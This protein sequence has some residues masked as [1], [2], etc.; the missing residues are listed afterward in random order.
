MTII[1]RYGIFILLVGLALILLLNKVFLWGFAAMGVGLIIFG[2]QQLINLNVRVSQFQSRIEG[3]E[4]KNKS[5]AKLNDK[6][7]EEITYLKERQFQISKIRNILELNLF[8]VDANFNR[9]VTKKET[10]ADDREIKYFGSLNISLQAK[11]GIDCKELRFKYI[12]ENDELIVANINPRFL[13]FGNRK[14]E[15]GFFEIFEFRSQNALAEKRWMTTDNLYRY[16]NKVKEDYRLN[17]EK[18][19]EKGPEEFEWIYKPIMQTVI[20]T[21]KGIFGGICKNISIVETGDETFV[22]IEKL[23]FEVLHLSEGL[24]S[25]G[26]SPALRGNG[27]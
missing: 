20:N 27:G 4:D 5:L 19:L 12:P 7:E 6:L 26:S 16:A 10:I 13:S 21:I 24:N 23:K 9:P 18:S 14:L 2:I 22:P 11:F 3:L 25:A 8:E 1:K 17:T 15:W